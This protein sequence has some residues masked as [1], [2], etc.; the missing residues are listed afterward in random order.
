MPPRT[1]LAGERIDA[2]GAYLVDDGYQC[3][4]WLGKML[5]PAFVQAAFGPTGPP[6][7]DVDFEPPVVADSKVNEQVRGVVAEVRRRAANGCHCTLTVIQQGNPSEAR[8]FPH[9]VEDRGAGG[10]GA[11]SYADFLIQLHRQVA[12]SGA[13]QR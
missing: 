9:L 13:H 8:L 4:L 5:D 2:R 12:Q 6:G 1:A 10:A 7:P 3:L 11:M